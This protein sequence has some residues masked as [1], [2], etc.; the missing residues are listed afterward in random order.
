MGAARVR[1]PGVKRIV[2]GLIDTPA[3]RAALRWAAR[4]ASA[5]G[6][7]IEVVTCIQPLPSYVW[8]EVLGTSAPSLITA[9]G[10]RA[11]A[12]ALQE[13]VLRQEFGRRF[14]AVPVRA[15]VVAGEVATGLA[16]AAAGA[17]LLA[18][19]RSHHRWFLRRSIGDRCSYLFEGPVVLVP[20]EH[21]A[22][23]DDCDGSRASVSRVLAA[24]D[25]GATFAERQ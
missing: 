12:T 4:Q 2:V 5:T 13:R 23:G 15:S 18:V 24:T 11:E 22:D 19:G 21:D 8:S 7:L 17:D 6:S 10:L 3:A 16:R 14:G 9:G 1:E 20:A 25:L